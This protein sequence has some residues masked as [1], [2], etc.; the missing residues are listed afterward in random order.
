MYCF[1]SS[2]RETIIYVPSAISASR[3]KRAVRSWLLL[4]EHQVN[5]IDL[6]L[7]LI[8]LSPGNFFLYLLDRSNKIL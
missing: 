3:A 8:P 7:E 6:L 2:Q 4:I 1:P 5:G